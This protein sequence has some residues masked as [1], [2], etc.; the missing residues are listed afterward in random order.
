M[1]EYKR[2]LRVVYIKTRVP[3]G[4]NRKREWRWTVHEVC[5]DNDAAAELLKKL[6]GASR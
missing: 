5:G 4:G 6:Q 1:S 3:P 2:T